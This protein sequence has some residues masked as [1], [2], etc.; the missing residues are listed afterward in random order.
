MTSTLAVSDILGPWRGDAPTGL[1]QRCRE[2]WDTPLESLNDL[3]V[4]TFLNQNIADQTPAHRGEAPHE[5]P[6]TR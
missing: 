5:R 2:A 3:M 6:G 1:I 4:A